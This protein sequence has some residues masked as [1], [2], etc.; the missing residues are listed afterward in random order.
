M[1]KTKR[2]SNAIKPGGVDEYIAE[3]PKEIQNKL[4]DIRIAIRSVAPDAIETVSYFGMPGYSY[5]G[6][7][8]SGMFVWFSFR[9]PFVRLHVRPQA[10]IR[11][12]KELGKYARTKAVVSFPAEK[13]IP[14]TLVKKLVKASLKAMKDMVE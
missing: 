6:Y 8:Y 4:R 14:K 5:E 10:F 3:W 11:H 1:A 2:K 13:P 9:A 12:K 7:D